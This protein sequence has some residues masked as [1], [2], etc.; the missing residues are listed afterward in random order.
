MCFEEDSLNDFVDFSI[1]WEL[2]YNY[3]VNTYL[4]AFINYVTYNYG[5]YTNSDE[6]VLP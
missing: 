2:H 4:I 1:S 6:A 3:N 5:Y